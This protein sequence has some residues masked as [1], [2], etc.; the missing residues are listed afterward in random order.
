MLGKIKLIRTSESSKRCG[1]G[2][3]RGLQNPNHQGASKC[4]INSVAKSKET[5]GY[6]LLGGRILSRPKRLNYFNS[7]WTK[8]WGEAHEDYY[9]P[10]PRA[11]EEGI[12]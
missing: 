7:N 4:K 8:S 12:E 11:G 9:T 10:L 1:N 3:N 6:T 2:H 5:P